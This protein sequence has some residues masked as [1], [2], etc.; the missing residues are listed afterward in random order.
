MFKK[1]MRLICVL[2]ALICLFSSVSGVSAATSNQVPFE[3]Y[4]Y[5]ED[6]GEERKA[7]YGRPMFET[8][9][10][11]DSV[12]LG[13][14]P[15]T[16]INDIC[17]G[18]DKIYI[19]DNT[20]RI[21]VL[22]SNYKLLKE[23]NQFK[24]SDDKVYDF[25]GAQSL[26][27]H[28]DNTIFVCDTDHAQVL[29]VNPDG[30][31]K[32]IY[33]LPDSSLIPENF[34]FKPLKAVMDSHGYLYVLSDGSYYGA[35]LY[36][37]DKS[38]TGF[39][40]ANDVTTNIAT[41]FQNILDRVF[42][43]NVKK[44]ASSRT[45]PYSFIDIVIDEKN[46]IYTATGKTDTYD[47]VGQIKKL[48]PGTGSNILD[49]EETNFTD[50]AFNTT[51]NNGVQIEQDIVGL[52]VTDEG[53]VFCLESQFGRVY[54]YDRSCRM[55]TAFGG[56]MGNGQQDGTFS[57]AN[58]ITLNGTDVL[59][60]DKLK[61]TVTIFKITD[62]GK[63]VMELIDITLDGKYK[64]A[65][66]G[67]QEVMALDR[68]F[69][70]AYSGIARAHLAEGEYKAA[71]DM[72][73][74]GYDRETYQLAFEFHRKNLLKEYF[75]LIFSAVIVIVA[76]LITLAVIIR[77]KKIK[78]IKS[79][80]IRLM[81]N[82]LI[83]PV[84]TFDEIKEKKQGSVIISFVLIGLFYVTAVT[85][86][87]CGGFLFTY[88]DPANFNSLWVLIRS[89]GLVVLWVL[90]N[91]MICTLMQGKGTMREICIVTSYSLT[92]III[93]RFLS[94]LFTNVLLPSEA[95]FLTGFETVAIGYTLFLLIVGLIKIHDFSMARLIGTSLL[96]IVW[97][98]VLVFLMILVGMLVQQ[99]GGFALTVLLE[100]IS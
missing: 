30:G 8:A 80:Q 88:Y 84:N 59:V 71:M 21:I 67:W 87:I 81:L 26:Y 4:T 44:S 78:I 100:I 12:S 73:K 72:A 89:A 70:P 95:L 79:K 51:F 98:A 14:K 35:L 56:G 22:D 17:K 11:I 7:V 82:T 25:S 86:V 74:K 16:Q 62:F 68:N 47:R 33:T 18:G 92:P 96:S 27:V 34:V 91:W 75:W 9:F 94:L 46:F 55:L 45:L 99:I 31:V 50:D 1:A 77:K 38:F 60:S 41:A 19:L 39:Y 61:N 3:S 54:L 66:E 69:Q 10:V 49:S 37:P 65:K 85:R 28:T 52:E 53:Y 90:S 20:S 15:L 29:R 93:E 83:H 76:L 97:L 43:N 48:N 5:W 57:A 23:I 24:G 40:G 6:I 42:P 32:D 63:K 13:I 58:S 64:E 2:L 36:A